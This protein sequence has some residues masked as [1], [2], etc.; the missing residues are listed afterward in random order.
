MSVNTN[1]AGAP[2]TQ[3]N[4]SNN[5]A[6]VADVPMAST[7]EPDDD[8]DGLT[9]DQL[10]EA[11]AGQGRLLRDQFYTG[12][13]EQGR[14]IQDQIRRS[15]ASKIKAKEPDFFNGE[16]DKLD[17]W[18]NQIMIYGIQPYTGTLATPL[19]LCFPSRKS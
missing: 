4:G 8:D 5:T 16:R 9:Q 7:T 15:T 6:P 11:L 12:L 13:S 1:N 17:N 18:I 2:T 3:G 10:Q 14:L 19:D